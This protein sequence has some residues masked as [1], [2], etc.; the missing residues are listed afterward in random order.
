MFVIYASNK[1]CIKVLKEC[2]VYFSLFFT[3]LFLFNLSSKIE[4]V[5]QHTLVKLRQKCK[6]IMS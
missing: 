3:S 4:N 2:K 6:D 5:G 1:V